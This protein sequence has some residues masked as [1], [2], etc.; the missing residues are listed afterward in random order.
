MTNANAR[1]GSVDGVFNND[2]ETNRVFVEGAQM[3]TYAW[4]SCPVLGTD[5]SRPLLTVGREFRFPIDFKAN[6]QMAFEVTDNDKKLFVDNLLD[7]LMKSWE[8]YVLL[9]SARQAAHPEYRNSQIKFPWQFKLGNIVFTNVQVQSKKNTGTV[10]KLAYI[11]QGPYRIIK[12]YKGGSY[13]LAPLV[14]RSRAT[15]K[16]QGSDLY[17][18]PQSLNPHQS[19]DQAYAN[20]HKKMISSPYKIIRLDGYNPMQ[21]WSAPAATS[22]A[23]LVLQDP[24][25]PNSPTTW[26]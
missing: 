16:K 12:N 22:Q 2:R 4:N 20:L 21:P 13:E 25:L 14:G 19:S 1:I 5:L 11:K 18:S 9:I 26:R 17:L 7:L 23:N 8:D 3:L 10:G 24:T 6:R 15:I